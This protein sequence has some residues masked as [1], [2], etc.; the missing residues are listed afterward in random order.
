MGNN[1]ARLQDTEHAAAEDPTHDQVADSEMDEAIHP[2]LDECLPPEIIHAIATFLEHGISLA[3][4]SLCSK[5]L[6]YLIAEDDHLWKKLLHDE[7]EVHVMTYDDEA[8]DEA[9]NMSRIG[10][11]SLYARARALFSANEA[12][13]RAFRE[14]N[15]MK[16]FPLWLK[17]EDWRM[18]G[19]S[20]PW[21]ASVLGRVGH[22]HPLVC[23]CRHPGRVPIVGYTGVCESWR[24]ILH[25]ITAYVEYPITTRHVRRFISPCGMHGEVALL[26]VLFGQMIPVANHFA[27]VDG[28]WRMIIH[29][30]Q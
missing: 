8:L 2:G 17:D 27:M 19:V 15:A 1:T 14:M 28:E 9:F 18:E 11:R 21:H 10:L 25:H 26:E 3:R 13:Y 4:L 24:A 23:T 22:G 29:D 7:L 12:F 16:M 20:P 30:V 5:Q 6:N